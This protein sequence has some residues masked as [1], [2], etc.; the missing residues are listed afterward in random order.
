MMDVL[1]K[2]EGTTAGNAA[3]LSQ[4]MTHLLP[5]VKAMN[6]VLAAERRFRDKEDQI[7]EVETLWFIASAAK[8]FVRRVKREQDEL[9]LERKRERQEALDQLA[10]LENTIHEMQLGF[11]HR[12]QALE[13]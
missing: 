2:H 3:W 12:R 5:L 9:K 13:N 11:Q 4:N 10:R 1:W 7:I 6:K 8:E